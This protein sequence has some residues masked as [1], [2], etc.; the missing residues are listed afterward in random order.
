MIASP[1]DGAGSKNPSP[2]DVHPANVD[3]TGF[4][5][6][7]P[8]HGPIVEVLMSRIAWGMSLVLGGGAVGG[9]LAAEPPA[10]ALR[11]FVTAAQVQPRKDVDKATKQALKARRDEARNARK[12]LEKQLKDQLGKKRD[13]WPPE[14]DD[15]LYRLEEAEALAEAEYEYRTI[16]PKNLSDAVK[17]LTESIQGKGIAG[18]KDR[19]ILA[20]SPEEADIVL[21]VAARRSGKTLPTQLKADRCFLLFDVRAGGKVPAA[22]FAKVPAGYRP[23]K[24][25]LAAYRI[26]AP[27]PE[28]AAFTF[29]SN[30]GGGA[31]FGCHG[32]AANAAAALVEKFIEDNHALLGAR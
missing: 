3:E 32:A 31:E 12:A 24:F 22:T 16:D 7:R 14:K 21:E 8:R 9:A 19:V 6:Y 1:A 15:E 11:V 10:G 13:T 26:A 28:K 20:A 4:E 2:A 5:A 30:N 18:R 27:R 17:D 25:G 23:K 29:E